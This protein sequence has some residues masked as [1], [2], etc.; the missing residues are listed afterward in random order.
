MRLQD[1][2]ARAALNNTCRAHKQQQGSASRPAHDS[3]LLCCCAGVA[4][5]FLPV[6][7][8]PQPS[9]RIHLSMRYAGWP[10]PCSC[11]TR[12]LAAAPPAACAIL[13]QKPLPSLHVV[14][15][16]GQMRAAA[17]FASCRLALTMPSLHVVRLAGQLR[18]AAVLDGLPAARVHHAVHP[19]LAD[20]GRR[21]KLHLQ[22]V[23]R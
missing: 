9:Q 3:R 20:G 2:P 7:V 23:S 15:L 4:A 17:V 6:N 19:H 13:H 16:T 11:R 8:R 12:Q 10:A 18:A 14:C 22:V 21:A 1:G 5:A